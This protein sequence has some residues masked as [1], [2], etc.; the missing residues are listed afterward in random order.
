CSVSASSV[1]DANHFLDT[2]L[3]EKVPAL[4]EDYQSL[5]PFAI[6]LPSYFEIPSTN[7]ITNRALQVDVSHG[8]YRGFQ[9]TVK[10]LGDCQA[11]V[12]RDGKTSIKCT[13]DFAGM[14]ANYTTMVR[15]GTF[16]RGLKALSTIR[17]VFSCAVFNSFR[18][19]RLGQLTTQLRTFEVPHLHFTTLYNSDLHLNTERQRQFKAHIE[20]KVKQTLQEALYADYKLQ[21]TRAVAATPFPN[22]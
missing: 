8:E 22:V 5:Y 15:S 18:D 16:Y 20:A 14:T 4:I 17:R 6:T 1:S 2:V 3:G 21:L 19:H 12:L 10:R 11:P 7:I 13:L 9:D